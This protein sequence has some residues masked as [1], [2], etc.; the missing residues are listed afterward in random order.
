MADILIRATAAEERISSV[1]VLSTRLTE[2]ARVRH[3]LSS[4]AKAALGQGMTSG[5]LL[6]SSMKRKG[7]RVNL[8]VKGDGPLKGFL[9][10]AGLDGT[11]RGYVDCPYV[12][13]PPQCD[14]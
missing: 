7:S 14:C 11:A 6:A 3:N 4:V 9:V 8:R 2:E 12:E 5:L 10:D 13:L 1:G